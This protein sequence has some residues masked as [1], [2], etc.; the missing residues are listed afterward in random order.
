MNA[1]VPLVHVEA[2]SVHVE[3]LLSAEEEAKLQVHQP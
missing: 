1:E 2:P 3:V